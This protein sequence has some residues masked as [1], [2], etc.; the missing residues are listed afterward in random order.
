MDDEL[1]VFVRHR[2]LSAVN[3][4][5]VVGAVAWNYWTAAHGFRGRTIGGLSDRYDTLF[6]PA[7][8]AFSIWGLIFFGLFVNAGYQLWLSFRADLDVDDDALRRHRQTFFSRLGPLL[9]LTNVANAVWIALWLSEETLASVATLAAMFVFLT[10]AMWRLEMETWDAPMEV[11]AFVWWPLVIYAGWVTVAVLAN[12]SAFLAKHD[13]VPGDSV[14]WV[15]A[16]IALATGYNL[17]LVA[18]R[19]LREHAAVAIWSVVAIAVEQWGR[20]EAVTW[21]AVAAAVVLTAAVTAHAYRNRRTLPFV[22]RS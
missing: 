6:T 10:V 16:M 20:V 5:V 8:Y 19:N 3:A 18:K 21:V 1:G 17:F 12:L 4:V 11:I 7:G 9:I 22:R 2:W 15:I 14:P 13:V